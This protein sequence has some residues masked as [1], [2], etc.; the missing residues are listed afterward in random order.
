MMVLWTEAT[1]A[2]ENNKPVTASSSQK[3]VL[4]NGAGEPVSGIYSF[5]GPISDCKPI[6]DNGRLIWY[7]TNNS[8][9]V[10]CTLNIDD[11]RNQPR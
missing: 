7:Y 2:I 11:V 3:C 4:L 8:T 1:I 10:F 9:P 6:V 5:D